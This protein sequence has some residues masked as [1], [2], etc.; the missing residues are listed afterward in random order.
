MP[1]SICYLLGWLHSDAAPIGHW[2]KTLAAG[3]LIVLGLASH[4]PQ[5]WSQV[6]D[7]DQTQADSVWVWDATNAEQDGV[8]E[9]KDPEGWRFAEVAGLRR[10]SQFRKESSYRPPHRSPLHMAL[11]KDETYASFQLDC[12]LK[13]THPDYGHRDVCLFFGY[14]GPD[15][16]YYVHLASEMDDHANQIFRVHGADRVKI[17]QTTSAGTAWDDQ[18]HQVRIVRDVE[19]GQIAV[20]F[21]DLESPV[22]TANDKTLGAGQIGVGS[23]DDTA[24]F[25]RLE[26]RRK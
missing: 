12:W 13:S 16:F 10:L 19:S 26:I 8:W 1:Q 23:F 20:Y 22:M 7:Q 18:W 9:F 2:R 21:D 5:T 14:Q 24:D 15:K 6:L 4:V 3:Y 17:S 11:L 25:R